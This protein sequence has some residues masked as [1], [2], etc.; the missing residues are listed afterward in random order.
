MVA[1]V[2]RCRHV[3]ASMMTRQ[4]LAEGVKFGVRS[5]ETSEISTDDV[6]ERN[7]P[8]SD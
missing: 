4:L 6:R 5:C 2:L 1:E 7:L 3:F 8:Y